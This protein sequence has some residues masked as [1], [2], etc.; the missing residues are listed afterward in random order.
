MLDKLKAEP[1]AI[2]AAV[3]AVLAFALTLTGLPVNT[4]GVI[5]AAVVA[6]GGVYGAWQTEEALLGALTT[7][8]KTGS[9]LLVTFH[10]AFSETSQAGNPS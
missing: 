1:L 10:Y 4:Q 9:V 7:V 5:M 6:V 3:E 8:I 2:I